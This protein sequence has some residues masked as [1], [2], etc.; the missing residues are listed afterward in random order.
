[1]EESCPGMVI[2]KSKGYVYVC[3]HPFFR[4]P[5]RRGV[6][7]GGWGR[8]VFGLVC[9]RARGLIVC[10]YLGY[11]FHIFSFTGSITIC[12]NVDFVL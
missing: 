10:I 3:V 8:L 2:A 11:K 12:K 7:R 4:L 5:D 9:Y 1:M 6:G